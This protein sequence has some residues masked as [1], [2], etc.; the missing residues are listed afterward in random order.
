MLR[1]RENSCLVKQDFFELNTV[2]ESVE[3]DTIDN[4]AKE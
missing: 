1:V 4:S 2:Q 3:K